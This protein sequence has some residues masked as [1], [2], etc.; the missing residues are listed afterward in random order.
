MLIDMEL[1]KRHGVASVVC[2]WPM[3]EANERMGREQLDD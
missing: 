2:P 3:D 1:Q